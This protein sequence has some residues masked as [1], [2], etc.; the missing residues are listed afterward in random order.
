MDED[1]IS[2]AIDRIFSMKKASFY[3]ILIFLLGF[4]LRFIAAVNLTVSADDMHHVA[5]AS[6]FLSAGRLITY[7]QSAGLWHAFTSIIYKLFGMTQFT[8]RFAA[9]LLGLLQ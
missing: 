8:S 2:K 3:L 7:D 1:V 4:A 6:N 9:L 5:H